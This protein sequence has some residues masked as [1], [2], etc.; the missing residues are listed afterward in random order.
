MRKLLV[1]VAGAIAFA[2][3]LPA[4]AQA[5]NGCTLPRNKTLW[6]DFAEGSTSFWPMF[7]K[8]G[9]VVAASNFI[10][11]AKIRAL[12]AKTVYMDINFRRRIGTPTAPIAPDVVVDRANRIFDYAA[13]SMRCAR[14][15]IALNELFGAGTAPP[16][17]PGNAQYRSDVL[18]YMRTLAARGARPFLL[19]STRPY[20]GGDAADWWREAASYGDLVREVYFSAPNIYREGVL[21]GNRSLRQYFRRAAADLLAIGIPS[22]KIGLM[23]GFQTKKGDGGREGLQPARAWYDVVKWQALSARTV[24][25]ELHI[26][27][28]WSWGWEA[29]SD[30]ERD[31]DKPGAACVWLWARSSKLCNGPRAAGPGFDASLTAGQIDFPRG[32]QCKLDGRA[33]SSFALARLARVTG[34]R[35]LTYSALFQRLVESGVVAVSGKDVQLAEQSIVSSR[36]GGSRAGYRTALGRARANVTLARGIIGDEV[37]RA[38][39]KAGLKAP[40][41]SASDVSDYLTSYGTTLTREVEAKPAPWWL[42][43]R[44]RGLALGSAAPF[45]VMK[46]PAGK[47]KQVWTPGGVI[48][49]RPLGPARPLSVVG[50]DA[51][52]PGIVAA[53]RDLARSAAFET[54]TIRRQ[55]QAQGRALCARDDLP[56][57]EAVDLTEYLPFLE[58]R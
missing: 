6:I 28:V 49:V 39:I 22:Q 38:R 8:P 31:P 52:R 27:S 12:G 55:R 24:A 4:H 3:L 56:Q 16:W 40:Y 26:A 10:Y 17:S 29:Y 5:Q 46:L 44:K 35:E 34:D 30:A 53:L 36:F 18:L 54:W 19:I 47:W 42:N 57:N 50:L 20:T 13:A 43:G 33:M 41:P 37:R 48:R 25:R 15:Y 32:I 58:L 23:L 2:G 11:P 51:G 7:A 1:G 9:V 21:R 14:P 45:A